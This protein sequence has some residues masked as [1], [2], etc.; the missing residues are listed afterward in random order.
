MWTEQTVEILKQLALE[1]RSAAWIAEAIGAPSRSAVIGK[2]NRIGIKL[3]GGMSAGP[4]G[5]GAL[6]ASPNHAAPWGR[7]RVALGEQETRT[8]ADVARRAATRARSR[9]PALIPERRR[10]GRWMFAASEV[11][12]MRRIAFA[13]IGE[14][15]CRWPVG[16]PL[17]DDFA[18]CGLQVAPGRAYC[19]G[20]CRL[21]Y[22]APTA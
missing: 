17:C 6:T 2:A 15:Q 22:R 7:K 14:A 10:S 16:D 4:N 12:E 8:P 5:A 20:H 9:L 21:V 13:D 1:G 18:Y 11:G 19:A 3:N